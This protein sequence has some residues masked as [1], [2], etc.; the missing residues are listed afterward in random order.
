MQE[1][2]GVLRVN[3]QHKPGVE[4]VILMFEEDAFWCYIAL[5]GILLYYSVILF[6]ACKTQTGISYLLTVNT[7][8]YIVQLYLSTLHDIRVRV[9]N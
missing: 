5:F 1:Y 3:C 6:V 9:V 7:M 8:H 4:I 2:F